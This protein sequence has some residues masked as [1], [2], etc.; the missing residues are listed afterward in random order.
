MTANERLEL[1]G[2]LQ[3]GKLA[4]TDALSGVDE[5]MARRK[6]GPDRWSILE[7]ME[8]LAV[9]ETHMLEKT[10]AA[11]AVAEPRINA[12]RERAIRERGADRTRRVE[13]PEV[14]R[15]SGRY[16]TLKK[17][18]QAFFSARDRAMEFVATCEADLRAQITEHP[19]IGSVNSYENLLIMAAHPLRHAK[20][21]REIRESLGFPL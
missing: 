8:H 20:Q 2:D 1:L 21:I 19:L 11:A 4:L 13:S 6:P 18:E 9:A 12:M 10:L 15:P 7:C 16:P 3:A 5:E 17:A 14:A